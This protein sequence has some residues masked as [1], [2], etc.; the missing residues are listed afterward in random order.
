MFGR[1]DVCGDAVNEPA[2]ANDIDL[3]RKAAQTASC[4]EPLKPLDQADCPD[5]CRIEPGVAE[6]AEFLMQSSPDP[7]RQ[8]P[9]QPIGE[10]VGLVEDRRGIPGQPVQLL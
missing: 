8:H 6:T 2:I 7:A 3:S 4:D 9:F 1:T 10:L 5:L